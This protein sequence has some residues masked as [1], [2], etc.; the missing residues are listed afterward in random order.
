[1]T[2]FDGFR[3][4][5]DGGCC[6]RQTEGLCLHHGDRQAFEVRGEGEDVEGGHH[7]QHVFSVP[8]ELEPFPQTKAI[9]EELHLLGERA[10]T[11]AEETNRHISPINDLARG[12]E[13]ILIGL[14]ATE[15]RDDADGDI[16]GSQAKFRAGLCSL[17]GVTTDMVEIDAMV[18]RHYPVLK[19]R[20]HALSYAVG[21]GEGRVI[22]AVCHTVQQ[23]RRAAV[24]IPT[25]VFGVDEQRP[26]A[27][28]LRLNHHT[29]NPREEG[30]V[31]MNDVECLLSEDPPESREP[32]R[33][34]LARCRQCVDSDA[35]ILQ[36]RDEVTFPRHRIRDIE[37]ETRA[38]AE[39]SGLNQQLFGAT[40]AEAPDEPEY[41]K[42]VGF[43]GQLDV[44]RPSRFEGVSPRWRFVMA[45]RLQAGEWLHTGRASALMRFGPAHALSA[46]E[47]PVRHLPSTA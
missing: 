13:E 11:D 34:T 42:R 5:P 46:I 40:R 17:R 36:S 27:S 8:E 2:I 12:S 20:G 10:L 23:S 41:A 39:A 4:T 3:E 24:L 9:A 14:L 35:S 37:V 6:D 43:A 18:Q 16:V 29:D 15:V 31:G 45:G 44:D 26:Q 38:I 30:R 19:R 22:E 32:H 33:C 21:H 7:S 25:V 28:R 1:M 47:R